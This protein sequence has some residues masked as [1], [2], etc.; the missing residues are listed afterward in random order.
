MQG[1][2][3][4]M[5]RREFIAGIGSAAAWPLAARAQQPAMPV[6]GYL[7]AGGTDPLMMGEFRKGLAET[8]FADG[9]N[10][11]IETRFADYRNDQLPALAAELVSHRVAVI[12]ATGGSP[13]ALAAKA[14]TTT[15]PIVFM[16]GSDPVQDGLVA[17]F[18]RPEGNVTGI[19]FMNGELLAKR[20]G[21]LHELMPAATRFALLAN[22]GN[23]RQLAA[24]MADAHATALSIGV[25]IE[26]FTADSIEEIDAAFTNLVAKRA[27]ALLIAPG[28]LFV[29]R[30]AQLATLAAHHALP[31]LHFDRVFVDVTGLMSYGASLTDVNRQAGVY[32]GRILKGEKPADLPVLRPTKFVFAIN[33]QTA[34]TLGLIIPETLLATADEV[35]Q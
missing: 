3:S 8:G 14:A 21:L 35:I 32:V 34:K 6:V 7:L 20:L 9:S 16:I 33:L 28:P 30:R 13:V 22:S 12:Y 24:V 19:S 23:P 11:A 18:N 5:R 17:S 15:I 29:R 4:R 31:T 27:E 10:V 25:Q 1:E 26:V 2:D